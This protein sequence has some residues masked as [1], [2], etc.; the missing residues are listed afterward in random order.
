MDP[1]RWRRQV[2]P[3]RSR[4][5]SSP[6]NTSAHTYLPRGELVNGPVNSVPGAVLPETPANVVARRR[7]LF[8]QLSTVVLQLKR[9]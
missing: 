3:Y 9:L 8:D 6:P 2:K 1:E 4:G 7:R 5:L